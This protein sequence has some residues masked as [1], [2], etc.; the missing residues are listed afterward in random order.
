MNLS[1]KDMTNFLRCPYTLL[2]RLTRQQFKFNDAIWIGT[3]VHAARTKLNPIKRKYTGE[4]NSA[5]LE[6]YVIIAIRKTKLKL[7]P[8]TEKEPIM[9]KAHDILLEEWQW[10]QTLLKNTNID[11]VY[12]VKLE[13]PVKIPPGIYGMVDGILIEDKLP[14]PI[15]YKTWESTN[16]STNRFQLTA[17]CLGLSHRYRM[18]VSR[19]ILQYSSPPHRTQIT[20]NPNDEKRLR[21]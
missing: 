12:P 21:T 15:E 8:K 10:E 3:L 19:G 14:Y 7:P 20:V 11:A 6:K 17:Y 16:A 1:I 13:E 18:K 9:Q 2:N 5:N 4:N